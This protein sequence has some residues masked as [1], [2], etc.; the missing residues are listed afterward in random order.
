[1]RKAFLN[2]KVV[3]F[4]TLM[5]TA[6]LVQ[7][8]GSGSGSGSSSGVLTTTTTTTSGVVAT[9]GN[10]TLY[11]AC[12]N[13][14]SGYTSGVQTIESAQYVTAADGT[15]TCEVT[16][17]APQV[18]F[19][20]SRLFLG[21]SY[22][23]YGLSYALTT[24]VNVSP[25]DMVSVSGSAE[26]SSSSFACSPSNQQMP[27]GWISGVN[28]FAL[29]GSQII[30]PANGGGQLYVGLNQSYGSGCMSLTATAT[31]TRCVDS[32]GSSHPCTVAA[33]NATN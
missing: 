33:E 18:S 32:S 16:F 12:S 9:A 30:V 27:Y 1:M 26:E 20:G 6:F 14:Y 21:P 3:V 17:E 11:G 7:A 23:Q 22:P 28:Y 19:E 8:C 24:S 4:A 31:I 5:T 15:S 2:R 29:N 10:A 13:L 25:Y